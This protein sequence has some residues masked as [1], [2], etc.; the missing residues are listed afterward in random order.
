MLLLFLHVPGHTG[1]W[2]GYDMQLDFSSCNNRQ[3][4]LSINIAPTDSTEPASD[5][6]KCAF[7]HL[8][9]FSKYKGDASLLHHDNDLA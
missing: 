5:Q 6:A 7:H 3:W 4:A 1:R 8:L 9:K 2:W